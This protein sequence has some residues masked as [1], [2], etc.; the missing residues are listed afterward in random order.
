MGQSGW[1]EEKTGKDNGDRQ[2]PAG[3]CIDEGQKQGT[4][5]V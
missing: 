5:H 4:C 2:L 1:E 3:W